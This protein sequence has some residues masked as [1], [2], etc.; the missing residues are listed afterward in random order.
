MW[1]LFIFVK[2][3]AMKNLLLI[4]LGIILITCN[5]YSQITI[6]DNNTLKNNSLEIKTTPYDSSENWVNFSVLSEY[7][8]YIGLNIY[9]PPNK[10]VIMYTEKPYLI[11]INQGTFPKII[12]DGF[13][14]TIYETAFTNIYNAKRCAV[15]YSK[16]KINLF[17]SETSD[18]YYT[19]INVL[20]GNDLD[21]KMN[22]W[23]NNYIVKKKETDLSKENKKNW[24]NSDKTIIHFPEFIEYKQ[25][26]AFELLTDK[27]DTIYYIKSSSDKYLSPSNFILVPYFINL[28]EK[29]KDKK[30]VSSKSNN[31]YGSRFPSTTD[32]KVVTFENNENWF[33]KNVTL[34]EPNY[35]ITFIIENET[36][37]Q[38]SVDDQ[39]ISK[40]FIYQEEFIK[41]E[42]EKDKLKEVEDTR[43]T[44]QQ[45]IKEENEKIEKEKHRS[46]Y[47]QQF[48]LKYGNLVADGKIEVGMSKEMCRTAYGYPS[49]VYQ[50][51]IENVTFDI[52]KYD[53]WINL[54]YLH[55]LNDKLKKIE[56]N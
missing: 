37:Q 41:L 1:L 6:T 20:Y 44:E 56:T 3:I 15:G 25:K 16:Q 22:N 23:K 54:V 40:C 50:S 42:A 49:K 13:E 9:L 7:K 11:D 18:K 46:E 10:D 48:G 33:C 29:Y 39:V 28:K 32:R 31:C 14:E 45:R 43:Y 51:K 55:F 47:I 38:L 2:T 12:V 8:K 27:K 5:T 35:E 52:W 36:N 53:A 26:I 21:L 17:S 30:L 34:L 4:T 24:K 19:I